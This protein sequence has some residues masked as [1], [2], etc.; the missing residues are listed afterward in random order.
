MAGKKQGEGHDHGHSHAHGHSHG[1]RRE[2]TD[3][4]RTMA[5]LA[6]IS[7]KQQGEEVR[8]SLEL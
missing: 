6:R 7:Q 1:I 5:R 3:G 2:D 8:R 4:A